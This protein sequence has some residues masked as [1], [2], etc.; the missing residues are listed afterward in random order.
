MRRG[1]V[2]RRDTAE[3]HQWDIAVENLRR[4]F[5]I[6]VRARPDHFIE[7]GN[8]VTLDT[9]S[10]SR[11]SD[12]EGWCDTRYGVNALVASHTLGLS[13][14]RKSWLVNFQASWGATDRGDFFFKEEN[15]ALEFK[16]SWG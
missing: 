3:Y 15:N 14:I 8:G 4:R 6:V 2:L 11:L 9:V 10:P 5:P 1:R 12:A 7:L 16:M 13:D